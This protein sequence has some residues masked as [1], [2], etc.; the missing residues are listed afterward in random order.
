MTPISLGASGP[1]R[2]KV[3]KTTDSMIPGAIERKA[4]LG[5]MRMDASDASTVTARKATG[6]PAA[7]GV[8]ATAA[9]D[10][11]RSPGRAPATS[12]AARNRRTRDRTTRNRA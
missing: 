9:A 10:A 3:K 7:A 5:T 11:A 6:Y 1:E 8:S 12:S 2:E 4:G